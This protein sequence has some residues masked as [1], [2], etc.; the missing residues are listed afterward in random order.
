MDTYTTQ[1]LTDTRNGQDYRVRKMPDGR[2]WMIDNLKLANATLTPSDSNVSANFTIPANPVQNAATHGN[3]TGH[4]APGSG[5]LTTDGVAYSASNYAFIAFTDPN[6]SENTYYDNCTGKNG[7]SLDSLT[8]CG[9]LYNWYTATAGTG[10]YDTSTG[11]A[12]GSICPADWTLP[13]GSNTGQ[14]AI[15]NN[16]MSTG[17]FATTIPNWY[18]NGPFEGSLA[19]SYGTGFSGAGYGGY[20]WS[21]SAY[22]STSA[23]GLYFYY[24]SVYTGN[25]SFSKDYG[26]AVRCIL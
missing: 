12:S 14:F 25:Y 16:A 10:T 23:Y 7:I 13:T 26:F 21:S 19:G 6:L 17:S 2:C 24:S 5:S 15:L 3:G 11:T 22:S 20:Y 1:V 9:Y 4:T 8:G 18:Y